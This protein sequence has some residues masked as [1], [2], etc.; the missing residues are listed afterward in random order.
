MAKNNTYVICNIYSKSNRYKSLL[1]HF[2]NHYVELGVDCIF[3]ICET[4]TKEHI[5]SLKLHL[6]KIKYQIIDD[7]SMSDPIGRVGYNDSIRINNL[8]NQINGDSFVDDAVSGGCWYIPADI[9]EFHE[10][11]PFKSF[12]E[13]QTSCENEGANF[14]K[15][16]MV[17]RI[18]MGY[19]L[20]KNIDI[21]IP[22]KKQFP[23]EKNITKDIM[24][25]YDF[26]C[27]FLNSQVDIKEG[28][29]NVHNSEA[30]KSYSKK[31]ITNHYKWFGDVLNDS[32]NSQIGNETH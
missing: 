21:A 5:D 8:K 31:F 11:K 29:H 1:P 27:I 6:D 25:A 7:G 20:P 10:I 12:K 32:K 2:I 4:K 24:Q 19:I 30:W 13:L 23:L 26:K 15:S 28:H 3:F 18:A 17:D 16:D 9:D 22:I 14:V